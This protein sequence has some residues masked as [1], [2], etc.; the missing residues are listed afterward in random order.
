M[1]FD[2]KMSQ[3]DRDKEVRAGRDLWRLAG[4]YLIWRGVISATLQSLP[5]LVFLSRTNGGIESSTEDAAYI[6]GGSALVTI[7][8]QTLTW[9]SCGGKVSYPLYSMRRAMLIQLIASI[10]LIIAPHLNV[11]DTD[12]YDDDSGK[13][14]AR[15]AMVALG[16]IG[17]FTV[18]PWAHTGTLAVAHLASPKGACLSHVL[19]L[20][21]I[22]EAIGAFIGPALVAA[23]LH[24]SETPE[25]SAASLPYT[26]SFVML[27]ILF[28]YS[29]SISS[30]YSNITF[31]ETKEW[32]W[33]R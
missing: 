25:E 31:T 33:R 27:V 2:E 1:R 32:E 14:A 15:T 18:L 7:I 16:T 22:A 13:V 4:C 10:L 23:G 6:F 21:P 28:L 29:Y 30:V 9:G 3:Q 5:L 26:L 11:S 24:S 20:A 12:N 17:I 8:V 19:A